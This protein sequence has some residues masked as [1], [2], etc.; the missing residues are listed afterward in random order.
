MVEARGP[1]RFDGSESQW[2]SNPITPHHQA[3]LPPVSV[4]VVALPG[5]PGGVMGYMGQQ[6]G[7]MPAGRYPLPTTTSSSSSSSTLAGGS[8]G[9]TDGSG[10]RW[11]LESGTSTLPSPMMGLRPT[12]SRWATVSPGH[13]PVSLMVGQAAGSTS[14]AAQ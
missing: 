10:G 1:R 9:S 14:G 13:V 12:E 5:G 3:A 7:G 4:V 11:P 2:A 6:E 8:S